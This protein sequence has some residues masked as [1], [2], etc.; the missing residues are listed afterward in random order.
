[1]GGERASTTRQREAGLICW[2]CGVGLSRP[3]QPGERAC[4]DCDPNGRRHIVLLMFQHRDEGWL[5]SFTEADCR[6][7]LRRKLQF[8]DSAK[9]IE[10]AKRGGA[11]LHGNH[12]WPIESAIT[13]GRGS[14]W[15]FLTTRQYRELK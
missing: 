13:L 7:S 9:L 2:K 11:M 15:L 1:M 12:P 10:L 14:Q 5:V 3:N 6:T 8:T 4:E